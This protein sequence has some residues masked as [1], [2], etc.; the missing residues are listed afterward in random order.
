MTFDRIR[1]F[2]YNT[3]VQADVAQ[4]VERL[5]RNQKVSGSTPLIGFFYNLYSK[6][7]RWEMGDGA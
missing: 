5:I 7:G 1:L 2:E 3:G 6:M 4:L